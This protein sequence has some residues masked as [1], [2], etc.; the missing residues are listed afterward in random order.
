ML[1]LQSSV[2][3]SIAKITGVRSKGRLRGIIVADVVLAVIMTV[4]EKKTWKQS[5]PDL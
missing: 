5:T 1:L 3:L 4:Q 2:S